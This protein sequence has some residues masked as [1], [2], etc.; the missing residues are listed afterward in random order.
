[1]NACAKQCTLAHLYIA[2]VH[3]V[4]IKAVHEEHRIHGAVPQGVHN[5][6]QHLRTCTPA[7]G[8]LPARQTGAASR[9]ASPWQTLTASLCS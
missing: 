4:A 6:G 1:M 3:A 5:R 2:G 7:S 8:K 9:T